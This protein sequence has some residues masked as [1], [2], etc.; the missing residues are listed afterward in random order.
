M[1]LEQAFKQLNMKTT[2]S[3]YLDIY[4]DFNFVLKSSISQLLVRL[5]IRCFHGRRLK[6]K[7]R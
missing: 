7:D 6:L 4:F 5:F 1:S 2:A 3:A